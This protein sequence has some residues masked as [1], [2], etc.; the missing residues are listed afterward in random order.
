MDLIIFDFD[1]AFVEWTGN[2]I[3]DKFNGGE[4]Q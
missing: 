2:R 3:C 4:K 1:G